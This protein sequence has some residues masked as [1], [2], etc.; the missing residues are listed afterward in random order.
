MHLL[1]LFLPTFLGLISPALA[2]SRTSPPSSSCIR[3]SKTPSAHSAQYSTLSSAINSLST[4]S[5]APV[6]I[7]IYPGTYQEQVLI[8]AS[9]KSPISIYGSTTNAASYTS[10]SVT[11][12]QSKSQANT[13]ASNDETGTVR[14][15]AN[16]V[17]IYNLNIVNSYGKGSQAVA[18]SAYADSGY[19]GCS[20]Q[21][22]QDTVLAN[23]GKQYYSKCEIVG[24]TDFIF[25]Q[26]A[27]AWFERCDI[28]VLSSS[29]GYITASGRSSSTSPNYYVFN[30]CNVA[31]RSGQSVNNG[32]YYLGR[33]W[34]EFARVV[35]QNTAM[36]SVINGAGW[37]IWNTG[38]E[39]TSNVYFGEYANSG[40]GASG[41]RA[42][43]SRKLGGPVAVETVLGGDYKAQGWFDGNYGK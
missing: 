17:K 27:P 18:L 41:T 2:Q 34:R 26:E 30:N 11:I 8:P 14:V 20:L 10:N 43:F 35:F 4:T 5:T 28:R 25:G 19:Y 1:P 39:R 37:R 29:V 24:V 12:T 23:R 13:G 33:P 36:S 21:G 16:N 6:C 38:D 31:A 9:I 32:A 22:Y 7:F 40:A 15:K 3:V 42:S